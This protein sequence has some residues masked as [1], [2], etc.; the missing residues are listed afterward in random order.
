LHYSGCR[1]RGRFGAECRNEAV[2]LAKAGHTEAALVLADRVFPVENSSDFPQTN[3]ADQF[4]SADENT[5][6][7]YLMALLGLAE[8]RIKH[9]DNM[10]AR[11]TLA[12]I[13][14]L[15]AGELG[16][17]DRFYGEASMHL[18]MRVAMAFA[19]LGDA[20]H[21]VQAANKI[22]KSLLMPDGSKVQ[23][24]P[25]EDLA[26]VAVSLCQA[27]QKAAGRR[28]LSYARVRKHASEFDLTSLARVEMACENTAKAKI[29][30]SKAVK[31][32]EAVPY[33]IGHLAGLTDMARRQVRED[34]LYAGLTEPF[35][36]QEAYD[37][38]DFMLRVER[39]RA[40]DGNAEQVLEKLDAMPTVAANI[41]P[42]FS[43]I[44]AQ[45][46]GLLGRESDAEIELEHAKSLARS[47]GFGRRFEKYNSGRAWGWRDEHATGL[48]EVAE[49]YLQLHQ[50]N[51]A[52]TVTREAL[53][54]MLNRQIGN[55]T[56]G[57]KDSTYRSSLFW[58]QF[59]YSQFVK[60]L[61]ETGA[62]Q[63]AQNLSAAA[64]EPI[65]NHL[66]Q[67]IARKNTRSRV[68]AEIALSRYRTSGDSND[69]QAINNVQPARARLALWRVA[70]DSAN[71]QN[72]FELTSLLMEEIQRLPE[73]FVGGV[74]NYDLRRQVRDFGYLLRSDRLNLTEADKILAVRQLAEVV[75]RL[76]HRVPNDM[77]SPKAW[78]ELGFVAKKLNL[79]E[80][81]KLYF[82]EGLTVTAELNVHSN[83][84]YI[85]E[86]NPTSIGACAFWL[87]AAGEQEAASAVLQ[88]YLQ[89]FVVKQPV[90]IN[91]GNSLLLDL[92]LVYGEYEYGEVQWQDGMILAPL[93]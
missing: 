37:I 32:A 3:I 41:Q 31:L 57:G 76:P 74:S 83:R 87:K 56:A 10:S 15:T 20:K 44:R 36:Q 85:D 9:G 7:R 55:A 46:L 5:Q 49:L 82:D 48:L 26:N 64:F 2:A 17:V 24:F 75:Q 91:L 67:Q 23:S 60:L 14:R 38:P 80:Y 50:P 22:P 35:W 40:L 89:E 70:L 86:I 34:M 66:A 77:D 12:E 25:D 45:V 8:G 93:N 11:Q 69:L 19:E 28:L 59:D 43:L 73:A 62:D 6:K 30:F 27:N 65:P 79:P 21:A 78:C 53:A 61:A 72:S 29:R 54:E 90:A 18:A 42:T 13:E 81:A 1:F 88:K 71:P 4:K 16:R 63:E 39:Q 92:A 68:I 58:P 52:L 51:S 47:N 84:S 33:K